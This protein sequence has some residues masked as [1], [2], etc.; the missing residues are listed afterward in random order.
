MSHANIF[1][2][3]FDEAT[4]LKLNPDVSEA[5]RNRSF[6]SG[7]EHCISHGLHED[8]PGIP[9]SIKDHMLYSPTESSP[10]NIYAKEFM[11]MRASLI[12]RTLVG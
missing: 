11:A 2:K 6:T 7:L 1:L 4:Y 5:V 8:R 12:L 10:P 9:Q 3:D